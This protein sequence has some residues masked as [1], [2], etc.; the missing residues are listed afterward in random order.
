MIN[1]KKGHSILMPFATIPFVFLVAS[2]L[3][4]L[5][6]PGHIVVFQYLFF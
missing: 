6:Y 5:T 4:A 3:A 1:N 2:L